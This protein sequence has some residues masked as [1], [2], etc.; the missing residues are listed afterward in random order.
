MR[1]RAVRLLVPLAFGI[2]IVV[3]PMVFLEKRF[4]GEFDVYPLFCLHLTVIVALAYIV[5]TLVW[6]IAAKYLAITS[7][8]LVIILGAYELCLRRVAWLRPLV[9]LKPLARC[10][11]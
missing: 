3:P 10:D 5:V 6:P 4:I 8:T 11:P 7:G 2:L 9:G 1:D